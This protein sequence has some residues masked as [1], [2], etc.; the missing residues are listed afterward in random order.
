MTYIN[1]SYPMPQN[2]GWICSKC[3]RSNSPSTPTCFCWSGTN[4]TPVYP[5]YTVTS[6][7]EPFDADFTKKTT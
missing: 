4:N 1:P 2:Y 7:A 5:S 3:G 6:M